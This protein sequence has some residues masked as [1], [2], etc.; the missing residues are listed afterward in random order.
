MCEKGYTGNPGTCTCENGNY[1]GSITGDSVVIC[2]KITET[3]KSILAKNITAKFTETNF[4]IW[5][6]F[7]IITVAVLIAII[8]YCWFT[9]YQARFYYYKYKCHNTICKWKEAGY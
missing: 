3:T 4:Y 9:K 8:I 1:L 7:L 2:D 5:L 6:V